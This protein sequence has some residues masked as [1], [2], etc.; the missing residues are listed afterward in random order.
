MKGKKRKLLSEEH[1]LKISTAL[2]NRI[3][4]N[5][6]LIGY[7]SGIDSPNFGKHPSEETRQKMIKTR[8]GMKRSPHTEET[9]RKIS[10]ARTGQKSSEETKRKISIANSGINNPNYGK[11]HSDEIR[12][13]IS[14]ANSGEN[15]PLF[16][17]KRPEH[18]EKMKGLG[19]PNYGKPMA[20]SHGL[21][22]TNK[23]TGEYIWLRSHWEM[24]V[25]DYL[26][27]NCIIYEYEPKTFRL[28]NNKS[29]T[30]DFYLITEEKY[31]EV[32]GYMR[33]EAKTKIDT[34]I[35][36]YPFIKYELWDTTKL[37][38]MDII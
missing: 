4:W 5:K 14:I 29:Y 37:R 35:K 26:Y 12:E 15:H 3:P 28:E 36:T 25:A 9:K 17:K 24:L 8:T 2:K 34:F 1:K 33:E 21:W 19:N 16:G 27:D 30:P 11:H 20:R 31:I 7:H 38:S 6:G 32:K 22:Y 23:W 18:S 13:K 10:E